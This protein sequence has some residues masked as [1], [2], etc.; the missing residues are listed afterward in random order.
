MTVTKATGPFDT[1]ADVVIVGSGAGGGAAAAELARAGLD[2]VV[3]EMGEV[4]R[5]ETFT[6]REEQ[7]MPR[8]FQDAGARA[9]ADKTITVLQGKGVGGSTLHNIN[10]CKRVDAELL[11][12]WERTQ[13]LDGLAARLDPHYAHM[14]QLL[15]VAEVPWERVTANNRAVRRGAEALGWR[16]GPLKHNR[17]GCVGSGFCELG[18]AYDAKMNSAR[19]LIPDAVAHGA[20]VIA[21]TKVTRVMHR[22]GAV[23]GVSGEVLDERRKPIGRF[24]VSAK[25]VVLSASAT[26]SAALALASGLRDP[27]RQAGRGLTLHPGG[28]VGGVMPDVIDGWKGIPQSWECTE[29][30]DPIDPDRRVWIVPVF[31]HPVGTAAMLPGVG[32]AAV[33]ALGKYRNI[34]ALTPMLH[35][36]TTGRIDA[37]TDARPLLTYTL[38]DEDLRMMAL[39]LSA[40]ARLLLAAGA[41]EVL[42]PTAVPRLVKTDA[43]A[44]SIA[45]LRLG[46]LDPPLA[47]VHPMGGMRMGSDPRTSAVDPYG[48]H[49]Q[50]RNLWVADG[51]LFPT[52][53][54]VPPQ[55]SIYALGRMVG[56]AAADSLLG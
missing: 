31:G 10:L 39:G 41:T 17:Q 47:A 45:D 36:L 50:H 29:F 20:R 27:Y 14:E 21:R 2:V 43:E 19:V 4:E 32:P 40:S 1:T 51:S 3:L 35:D 42:I 34:A 54:G 24:T 55:L 48:R 5:P 46:P 28:T 37:T 33:A 25:A 22:F 7:M 56:Q 11:D 18:C 9:T 52:S 13:G 38:V 6:Q 15:H 26:G 12:V 53:T 30:L 8:L 44:R 23:R 16:N 49:H